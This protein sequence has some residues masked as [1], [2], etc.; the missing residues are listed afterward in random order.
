MACTSASIF[1][2]LLVLT[3]MILVPNSTPMV[4]GQSAMTG[5]KFRDQMMWAKKRQVPLQPSW[6]LA[7]IIIIY[8][9]CDLL[10]FLH[11]F[12]VNWCNKQL[13]PTPWRR[14]VSVEKALWLNFHQQSS[15]C[16]QWWCIWICSCSC[17]G[18]TP[19]WSISPPF[20]LKKTMWCV[21]NKKVLPYNHATFQ[22]IFM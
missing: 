21:K 12:S 10:R 3:S 18:P 16:P 14:K 6:Q 8:N 19:F 2:G 11:F 15:P 20:P 9:W 7:I 1:V 4:W 13:L 22:G 5:R 17:K